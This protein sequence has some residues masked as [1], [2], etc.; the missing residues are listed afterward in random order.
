M[1]V[2][3]AG[4]SW[5]TRNSWI[6]RQT[7]ANGMF[8]FS[9]IKSSILLYLCYFLTEKDDV[10]ARFLKHSTLKCYLVPTLTYTSKGR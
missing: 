10:T 9:K 8:T 5:F 6:T 1:A 7:R 3:V 2:F 4:P